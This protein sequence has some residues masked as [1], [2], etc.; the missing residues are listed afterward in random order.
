MGKKDG[1][2]F[3]EFAALC[4]QSRLICGSCI[5][6]NGQSWKSLKMC[7]DSQ[8]QHLQH[9]QRFPHKGFKPVAAATSQWRFYARLPAPPLPPLLPMN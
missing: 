2:A 4:A 9:L 7:L 6:T 3:D 8:L 1:C 5:S